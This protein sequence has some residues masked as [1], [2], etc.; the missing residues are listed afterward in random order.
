[1]ARLLVALSVIM[2]FK[3]AKAD[4]NGAFMYSGP[5]GRD[6][7]VILPPQLEQRG[8]YWILIKLP[9]VIT[10]SGRQW[11]IIV[12]FWMKTCSTNFYPTIRTNIRETKR[13]RQID[14]YICKNGG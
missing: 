5:I 13:E 1:M 6:V 3:M 10:Q 7:Y 12:E 4:V 11:I 9:Y 2:E 8:E 14:L